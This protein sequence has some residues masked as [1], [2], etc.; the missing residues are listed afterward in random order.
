MTDALRKNNVPT[1]FLVAEDEGHG[2]VK[3]QNRDYLF[4]ATIEFVEQYLLN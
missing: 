3:K 2:Y 4:A 1:W